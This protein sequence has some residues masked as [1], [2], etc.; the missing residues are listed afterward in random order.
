MEAR[1]G[2]RLQTS[3][4][5]HGFF[6]SP[7]WVLEYFIFSLSYIIHCP[8]S[9]QGAKNISM[10]PWMLSF[11][12][13]APAFLWLWLTQCLFSF[14]TVCIRVAQKFIKAWSS[15]SAIR[16]DA[17]ATPSESARL[18]KL[19][20]R[21]GQSPRG[22]YMQSS[23]VQVYMNDAFMRS[24]ARRIFLSQCLGHMY[25]RI[26][27]FFMNWNSMKWCTNTKTRDTIMDWQGTCLFCR[28]S[29]PAS[30]RLVLQMAC[31]GSGDILGAGDDRRGMLFL[32]SKFLIFKSKVLLE[33]YSWTYLSP[34]QCQLGLSSLAA[35]PI[36]LL[37]SW[38]CVSVIRVSL[39]EVYKMFEWGLFPLHVEIHV[40]TW[41]SRALVA[42]LC[43][44]K[45]QA[46]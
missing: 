5:G 33:S 29:L 25:A 32:L 44:S 4:H 19:C 16:Q 31:A 18:A 28:F 41:T 46:P 45:L 17:S 21:Y 36:A 42:L 12:S 6:V 23:D 34:C 27:N 26:G 9:L 43:P 3:W 40:Y 22:I 24:K 38:P 1:H 13:L 11:D 39:C 14:F 8:W 10:I 35:C 2:K 30:E 20:A 37:S 15:K 7:M